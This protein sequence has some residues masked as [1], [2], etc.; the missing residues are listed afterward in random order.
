MRV[1]V[2][3]PPAYTPPYDHS[4]C[5]ALA[6]RGVDVELFTSRFRYGSVPPEEGYR[7]IERFYRWA[8]GSAALKAAQH[9]VDMLR[10]AA[11]LRGE[12]R[13]PVHFQWL[14]VKAL[15]AGLVRRFQRPRVFT[16]HEALPRRARGLVS[17]ID[18]VVV[19]TRSGRSRLVDVLGAA[20][21]RVHVIPHGAFDYLARQPVESPMD[22]RVGDLEGRRVVLFFGLLRPYKGIEV[23]IEAFAAAPAD[24]VLLIVGMPR[25]PTEPLVRFAA[26]LGIGDR[27]RFVPRF[28][29]DQEVPA[30]FRRADLVVLP[31]RSVEHS[32]VL[33]TA[34]AFGSP[35]VLSAVGGFVEVA[36][37]HGA[38]RLVEP[39]DAA[40]LRTAIVELLE[41]PAERARLAAAA[42]SAAETHYSWERSAEL[43][44]TLY[45]SLLEGD[46]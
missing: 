7:R 17:A 46:G 14:P 32:G 28:I 18:A 43:T 15:D 25:M 6:R 8:P 16:A 33:F 5:A 41:D 1:A 26:D 35:L 21:E 2:V 27:V 42:R 20:P 13:T 12:G 22:P 11:A 24:A 36:E 37:E 3:D 39:G 45:R 23:L 29:A 4:L 9:P 34:L 31:Y 19:H 44:E 38:A 30:Y 10:L 40:S